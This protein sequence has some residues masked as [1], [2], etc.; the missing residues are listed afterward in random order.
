MNNLRI[1][2]IQLERGIEKMR[3]ALAKRE[4]SQLDILRA[5]VSDDECGRVESQIVAIKSRSMRLDKLRRSVRKSETLS[6]LRQEMTAT[7]TSY[8]TKAYLPATSRK[9]SLPEDFSDLAGQN[10]SAWRSSLKQRA[11]AYRSQHGGI[12]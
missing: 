12:N 2:K 3:K 1:H 8:A 10:L 6:R 5:E 9:K 7:E 11:N 4:P